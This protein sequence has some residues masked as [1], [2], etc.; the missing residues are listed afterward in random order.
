MSN[1]AQKAWRADWKQSVHRLE[2]AF[3]QAIDGELDQASPPLGHVRGRG[4][5]HS[6]RRQLLRG[7][8]APNAARAALQPKADAI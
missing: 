3:L 5:H 1:C 6:V 7:M 8:L 2:K 4:R